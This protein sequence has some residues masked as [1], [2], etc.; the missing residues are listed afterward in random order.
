MGNGFHIRVVGVLLSAALAA[1]GFLHEPISPGALALRCPRQNKPVFVEVY[2]VKT[3]YF[4]HWPDAG[5]ICDA[6]GGK[7]I[8]GKVAVVPETEVADLT[9]G[10]S[11]ESAAKSLVMSMM[12]SGRCVV[13]ISE[14]IKESRI[15]PK[16]I[17]ELE[18]I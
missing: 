18:G 9:S 13:Q 17:Q 3:K 7:V 4:W 6:I 14:S 5:N 1:K 12:T 2:A 10:K 15:N 16:A 8:E 11:G